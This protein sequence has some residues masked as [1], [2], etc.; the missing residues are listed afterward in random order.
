MGF[1]TRRLSVERGRSSISALRGKGRAGTDEE[2]LERASILLRSELDFLQG[3]LYS[4]VSELWAGLDARAL[5][6]A[7]LASASATSIRACSLILDSLSLKRA[8]APL[9]FFT[10]P[11]P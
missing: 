9:S 10:T 5:S 3:C 8:L 4:G 6:A 11:H 7:V 2:E 1:L